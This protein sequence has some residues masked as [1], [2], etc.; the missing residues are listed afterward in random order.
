MYRFMH[1]DHDALVLGEVIEVTE[2][3]VTVKVEKQIISSKDLNSSSPKKQISIKGTIK[4]GGIKEYAFFNGTN[5][6]ENSPRK[7]DYVLVSVIKKGDS[8]MNEWGVYKV[9]SKDYSTLNVLFPKDA[10]QDS[11]MNA[12]AIKTF[13][14]SDG[15]I[16]DFSFDGNTGKVYSNNKVIYEEKAEN[17][18]STVNENNTTSRSNGNMPLFVIIGIILIGGIIGVYAMKKKKKD[19]TLND[20]NQRKRY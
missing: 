15:T 3:G 1:N 20:K 11:K 17:N 5:A 13:I 2:N 19:E 10:S 6:V 9:D 7:G 18:E 12:A 14:N 8:Y 16:N 4:I